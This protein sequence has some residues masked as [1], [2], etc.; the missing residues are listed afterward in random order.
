MLQVET[1]LFRPGL[2][3]RAQYY[4]VTFLNQLVLSHKEREGGSDL[5]KK[6]ID[7]YFSLFKLIMQGK[8]GRAAAM[9]AQQQQQ[10]VG[11]R[12]GVRGA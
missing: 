12:S 3:D 6:L 11:G 9:A 1:F 8:M 4:A 5:A 7:V 2:A 10:Q